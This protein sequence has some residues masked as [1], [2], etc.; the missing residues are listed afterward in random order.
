M[1][2]R[3]GRTRIGMAQHTDHPL[4]PGSAVGPYR[5]ERVL[6]AGN[7]NVAYRA[8]AAAGTRVVMREFK[9][10]R[11]AVRGA[12][13]RDIEPTH[14]EDRALFER[15]C[16][17]V[18]RLTDEFATF[19]H[20]N[21]VALL[22]RVDANGTCYVAFEAVD[23]KPFDRILDEGDALDPS[24]MQEILPGLL[25]GLA[26]VHDAGLLHLDLCPESLILRKDGLVTLGRS[27]L[28]RR[29]LSA[30]ERNRAVDPRDAYRAEEY[31]AAGAKFGTWSDI[32]SLGAA[33]YRLVTG[34]APLDAPARRQR[35]AAGQSDPVGQ[36]LDALS[37]AWPKT[38]LTAIRHGLGLSPGSRPQGVTAFRV[39]LDAATPAEIPTVPLRTQTAKAAPGRPETLPYE[40]DEAPT[41][42]FDR[43][44]GAQPAEP[45]RPPSVLGQRARR[46]EEPGA[47]GGAIES[48][49]EPAAARP[50]AARAPLP[51]PPSEE[52]DTLRNEPTGARALS[53]PTIPPGERPPT[54][55]GGG[56]S[57]VY[58][59]GKAELVAAPV[60]RSQGPVSEPGSLPQP[61]RF[62]TYQ[63]M[64]VPPERW[65][66]LTVYLHEPGID[67]VV[68][69]DF[70]A[71]LAGRTA[72]RPIPRTDARFAVRLGGS[73]TIVPYL[74]GCRANPPALTIEW[75]ENFH[76]FP[77]RIIAAE[78]V[79]GFARTAITGTIG[80]FVGPMLIG[81]TRINY[82]I[83]DE[84]VEPITNTISSA[85][86][87][88]D[89]VYPA[90]AAEDV[91]IAERIAAA[92]EELDNVFLT[93]AVAA[94]AR[95][96]ADALRKRI[97]NAE[98]F[99]L[100]W[101]KNA[102]TSKSLEE[103]WR[104]ALGLGRDNFLGAFAWRYP[105]PDLPPAL[106]EVPLRHLALA[107][108]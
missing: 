76:R 73:V 20:V 15:G 31:F 102:G 94:R 87:S 98:R 75:W 2:V 27:S 78:G 26:G 79:P 29:R 13:G 6:G 35:L 59:R 86:D 58:R 9:P 30:S 103:E 67:S 21:V 33:L 61:A 101:S 57:L 64:T 51:L 32:Y 105:T 24:E 82:S 22:D 3:K 38:V 39:A 8:S 52:G 92:G 36:T 45:P 106:D 108:E 100:F 16:A 60:S 40:P 49:T 68:R 11:I 56:T 85:T 62:T 17:E 81:E 53:P 63:P 19:R 66:D 37:G 23:G 34:A 93:E 95:G 83:A 41:V 69:Q 88:L 107:L 97:E 44:R 65:L 74:P 80:I 91:D 7:D 12:N 77:F 18:R 71:A 48:D 28:L 46:V 14:E 5:I 43:K 47:P 50:A 104:F 89:A 1:K 90:F 96:A 72:P 55:A 99:Q 4:S 84:D 70:E 25:A 54:P 42:R 10:S